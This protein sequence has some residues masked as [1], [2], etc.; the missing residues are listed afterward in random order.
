MITEFY[1]TETNKMERRKETKIIEKNALLHRLNNEVQ[2]ELPV[3]PPR[4]YC[5]H[6]YFY[7]VL[8]PSGSLTIKANQSEYEC[9]DYTTRR[10]FIIG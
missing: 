4:T 3:Y 1:K 9:L 6:I 7:Q 8:P 10:Y 2:I 5:F